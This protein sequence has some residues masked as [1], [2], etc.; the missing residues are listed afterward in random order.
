M[1]SIKELSEK[2]GV[3]AS[4]IYYIASRLGR[5][6]TLDEI[7]D[8]K[9]KRG[10]P[11]NYIQSRTVFKYRIAVSLKACN[12]TELNSVQNVEIEVYNDGKSN[13]DFAKMQAIKQARKE[14]EPIYGKCKAVSSNIEQ[15][16]KI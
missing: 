2:S 5:V 11:S 12:G 15:C 10:R 1:D 9:P 14:C 13:D 3:K 7:K 16:S 8:Y 4:R 6:P